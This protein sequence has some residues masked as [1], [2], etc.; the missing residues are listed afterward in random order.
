MSFSYITPR[1]Y[2]ASAFPCSA[3]SL[4]HFTAVLS[5]CGT[6]CPFR[7]SH[8]DCTG[9]RH[10]LFGSKSVPLHRSLI[11]L[12]NTLSVFDTSNPDCTGHR[13]PP[14]RQQV[15]TTSPQSY[16]PAEHLVLCRYIQPSKDWATATPC[17]ARG[18]H[19]RRAVA[20]SPLSY[21]AKPFWKSAENAGVPANRVRNRTGRT[22][23]RFIR[24]FEEMEGGWSSGES[25]G[26]VYIGHLGRRGHFAF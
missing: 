15:C 16:N 11:I 5:S 14:V 1:L 20:K 26:R 3:A 19:S 23:M 6:P 17:S 18:V 10:P 21:A 24:G 12:W 13:H 2:W 9:Q 8:P 4:Y 25:V 22:R 7:T